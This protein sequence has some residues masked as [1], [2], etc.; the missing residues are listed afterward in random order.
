[1]NAPM[2]NALVMLPPKLAPADVL[3]A[4]CLPATSAEP[5]ALLPGAIDLLRITTEA[6]GPL[7]ESDAV[8]MPLSVREQFA[9]LRKAYSKQSGRGYI[10]AE[11]QEWFGLPEELRMVILLLA[12][13]SGNLQELAGR[14]WRETPPPERAAIKAAT[15]AIKRNS[16][17]LVALTSLW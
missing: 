6:W 12:K 5:S 7:R 3:L 2:R 8:P 4:E 9:A 17:R 1:M 16:G 15:R 13:V 11:N 14:D 10:D